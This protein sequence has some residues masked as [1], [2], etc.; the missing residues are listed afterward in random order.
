M[1]GGVFQLL[2]LSS[3]HPPHIP[4]SDSDRNVS[5]FII[6]AIFISIQWV[7]WIKESAGPTMK[8]EWSSIYAN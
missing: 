8:R 5:S 6:K 4:E 1:K 3:S 2:Q 7:L